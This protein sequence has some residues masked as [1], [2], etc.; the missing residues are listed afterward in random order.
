MSTTILPALCQA[1]GDAAFAEQHRFH[2]RRVR[3]HDDDDVGALGHFGP[4]YRRWRRLRSALP[5]DS[6][7]SCR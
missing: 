2:V 1:L 5:A 4:K 3:H 6:F 7:W